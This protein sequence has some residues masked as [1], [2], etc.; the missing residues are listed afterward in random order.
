MGSI[1][2]G[3]AALVAINSFRRSVTASV[4]AESRALLGADLE[5]H[6][7]RAFSDT[8]VAL[9]DSLSNAGVGLSH[10]TTVPSMAYAP[11]TDFSRLVQIKALD[12][13]FPY[14]GTIGTEPASA[15]DEFR[16]GPR[17][18][19]DPAVAIEL[20]VAVGDT[21]LVNEFPLEIAGVITDSPGE[22]SFQGAI[23]PRVFVSARY[24]PDMRLIQFGSLVRFQAY[25]QIADQ[26]TLDNFIDDHRQLM[27]AEDVGWDTV[28]ERVDELTY[29]VGNLTRFL[30]LIGLIALLLGGVGVASAIHVFIKEKLDT[31]AVLRCLGARQRTVFVIY[32]VQAAALGFAGAALGVVLGIGV[33]LILPGL[34][35]DIIPIDVDLRVDWF[36]AAV[37]LCIGIWVAGVFALLPMLAI[38]DVTPLRALRRDVETL[39]PLHRRWRFAAFAFLVGSVVA[40]SVWQAPRE[41]T[42]LLFAAG[43]GGTTAVLWFTARTLIRLTRRYFPRRARYVVRQGVANLFRPQ[44]QTVS[45]TIALGFGAFLVATI[46]VVQRNILDR[47]DIEAD[48]SQPNFAAFDIQ[49]DQRD[50]VTQLFASHSV[51]VTVTPIIPAR[52]SALRGRAV[53]EWLADTVSSSANGR[54]DDA[55]EAP[56]VG[57]WAL[58][59]EYRHT[60]RDT[61]V[62]T[63]ELTA[64]TWWNGDTAN[65]GTGVV[66]AGSESS[67][68]LARISVEE[69]LAE[70]LNLKL[71]DRITWNIQGVRL[72]SVVTS[73]RRVNWARMNLNFFVV[74]EPGALDHVPQTAITLAR[75]DD[76]AQR[77][78]LQ[79][80]LVRRF[81]NI[82]VIDL[83]IVQNALQRIVTKVTL[84]IRFMA[85]FSIASG[86]VV[87]IGA[88]STSRFHRIRESVLL[89]TLG[90]SKRQIRQIFSTEY[91]TLGTLAGLTGTL[92]AALAGWVL[93]RFLF[94]LDFRLP[95]A[96]LAIIWVLVVV[97]TTLIGLASSRT[98]LAKPP[99]AVIREISE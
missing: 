63:E 76:P 39:A 27:R 98:V 85:L 88:L 99:L 15:W 97:L 4:R 62:A 26:Q 84:A 53:E 66:D 61:L 41:G 44:N 65:V 55:N 40:I 60:Y 13:A 50:G 93:I 36:I 2:L 29:A 74:F 20:D 83:S 94:E 43:I 75:I 8:I 6:G 73:F 87:L 1:T 78:I 92:L 72:E 96:A 49:A 80:D 77:A 68:G 46:Y 28:A 7:R 14:Y 35:H 56:R 69:G 9:L 24:L 71:G 3:V 10:M 70:D 25:L 22:L 52:M 32:L 79:R 91:V 33:Q 37:G 59:R 30:G 86:I 5:I 57:R 54:T 23:G 64:G 21:I 58:R 19:V 17:A 42:G 95:T 81:P 47:F 38:W 31:V 82:S 89:K 48:E 11:N 51:P 90:A 34:L 18:V 16:N 12:G 67:T 45:V